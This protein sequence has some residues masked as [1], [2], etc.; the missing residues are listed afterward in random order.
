MVRRIPE[1]ELNIP[2]LRAAAARPNGEIPTSD[3]IAELEGA[4]RPAGE[5]AQILAGR[6]DTKFSQKVRNLVSHRSGSSSIFSRGFAVYHPNRKSIS[7]TA[8]GRGLI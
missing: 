5:D 8:A 7:I 2:A 4:L 1:H 3:L 6:H